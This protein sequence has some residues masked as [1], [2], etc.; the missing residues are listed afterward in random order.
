MD[1]S[2]RRFGGRRAAWVGA[3]A[4]GGGVVA[5]LAITSRAPLVA[6]QSTAFTIACSALA[7]GQIGDGQ[8]VATLATAQLTGT[9]DVW[10]NYV[11]LEPA[12]HIVCNYNLPA[13]VAAGAITSLTLDVN[14]RGPSL[15]SQLW[16]FQVLDATTGSWVSLGNNSF[17]T[18]WVWTKTTFTFPA[19]V[20]RFFSPGGLLQIRYGTDSSADASNVD[21]ML[22]RGIAGAATTG[23]GGTTGS[24]GSAGTTGRGGTTGTA[25][26]TGARG[27]TTGTAGTTGRGGTTGSAG[28]TGAGA[29]T[30]GSTPFSMACTSLASGAIGSGQSISALATAELTGTADVWANYVE[31]DPGTQI[32]CN[33]N[34]PSGVAAGSVTSM[35]LQVNYRGPS[36]STQLWTFEV[37][38]TTTGAWVPLGDNAFAAGWI[39]TK[40]AFALPA[41]LARYF[42]STGTLQIRYGTTSSADASNVDQML[43]S[44][45]RG[46]GAGGS[47][48]AGA[49]T[50][51]GATTG[52]GGRGGSSG[53]GGFAGICG[54]PAAPPARYQH[55]V[56]FSFENRTWNDVGLGFSSPMTP[57]LRSL[58][59][60]CSDFSDYS[61]TNRQ[62]DSLPQYIGATSG[63]DNPNT[64][65][66]CDP[67][68]T[69][70]STDDNI[71]RQLRRAG[72]TARNYVEGATTGCSDAWD[73]NNAT[74]HIPALYYYGTY[75]DATGVHNDHDFCNTEVRPYSEFDV[76][77][78]PTFAFIT[79]DLCNDG[80][81]CP[82]SVVNAWAAIHVQRVLD[83]AAYRS[84][85]VAV[86]IWYD[87]D[88]PVPNAVIAPTSRR[89]NITQPGIASHAAL[90]KTW[91]DMLG[92]PLLTQGQLAGATNLRSVLGL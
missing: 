69:C 76:N 13:G 54:S 52:A 57:Y 11:E 71:F 16:T 29:T 90:L 56:V 62:Q 2:G 34:L 82:D 12:T 8:S 20:A 31:L 15:S 55:V 46:G 7:S 19:P 80:H 48:G 42:S 73:R 72:G 36:K 87:E 68:A 40:A 25:G 60:Q 24:T 77:N 59:S 51:S 21:Q 86:F 43:I 4:V 88:Y 14:Y 61:E 27:G 84:G 39:W 92:L 10:T 44:A 26:T 89:G 45:V 78:L 83:S 9:T 6:A 65:G 30:G 85:S 22:I 37:R 3:S 5:L 75:T 53:G 18:G 47:T 35:A 64:Y 41:P 23:A 66:G 50:G 33:Y 63:V 38:D 79:P 32:V 58:A 81:D 91:Q 17:A 1:K 49:G 28:T 74:R 70:R 67:S